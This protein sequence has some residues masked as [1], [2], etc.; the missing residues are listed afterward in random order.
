MPFLSWHSWSFKAFV[1]GG[2]SSLFGF[3]R[4]VSTSDFKVSD[5]FPSLEN[6]AKLISATAVSFFPKS[7]LIILEFFFFNPGFM[8][9]YTNL[10]SWTLAGAGQH[11]AAQNPFMSVITKNA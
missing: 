10:E 1:I 11:T 3:L 4:R 2:K 5:L 7:S 8:T 6:M 9:W